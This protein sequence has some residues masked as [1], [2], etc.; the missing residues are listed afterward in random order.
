MG[1]YSSHLQLSVVNRFVHKFVQL[2][3][4]VYISM[5]ASI[6]PSYGSEPGRNKPE[7]VESLRAKAR[8]FEHG[9]GVSRDIQEAIKLY[10]KGVW[11]EDPVS[12]YYLGWIYANARGIEKDD[13]IAAYL[14]SRAAEK[15]DAPSLRMLRF[16]G[17]QNQPLTKPP[18]LKKLEDAVEGD[19]AS[20]IIPDAVKNIVLRLAPQYGVHPSLALSIIRVESNFN[21][22]AV[23]TKNAQGLMQLIPETSQRFN[24]TKPFDPEQNIR[25]GLAYLRWLLA[26][27]EG[28]ISLVAAAY[29][30]GEGAVNRY[31]GIPPYAETR[32]YVEKVQRYYKQASHPFDPQVTPPS[33]DL[34]K[35]LIQQKSRVGGGKNGVVS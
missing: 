12:M 16:V 18:C 22:Q 27:F 19:A 21:T 31:R 14:F 3:L 9:E 23:S 7:E 28:D 11:L 25:G 29:N 2:L 32:A 5:L 20:S 34:P 15:G 1:Y 35:I 10:C 30:A 26:Y 33:P 6:S 17:G 24:V 8:A 4:L 13:S